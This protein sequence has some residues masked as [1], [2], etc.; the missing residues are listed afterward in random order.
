MSW[1]DLDSNHY[2]WPKVETV[3]AYRAQ[4]RLFIEDFILKMPI[5]LPI[6]QDQ[7]AYLILMCCEHEIIHIETSLVLFR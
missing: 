4:V 6:T 2:N 7:Q 1:D 5:Q 3:T